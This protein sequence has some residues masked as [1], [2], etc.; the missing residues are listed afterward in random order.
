MEGEDFRRPRG[1][2][3]FQAKSKSSFSREKFNLLTA[4]YDHII[5]IVCQ[6][7]LKTKKP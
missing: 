4:D 3:I 2:Q 7:V 5:F 1:G 6:G